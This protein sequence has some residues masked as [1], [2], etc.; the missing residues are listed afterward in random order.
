MEIPSSVLESAGI[1]QNCFIKFNEYDEHKTFA[2]TIQSELVGLYHRTDEALQIK[3]E[4]E[5][6]LDSF[7]ERI[8]VVDVPDIEWQK[9][10]KRWMPKHEEVHV[11]DDSNDTHKRTMPFKVSRKSNYSKVDRDAGSFA[12]SLGCK[13][14]QK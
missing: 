8:E 3:V 5:E 4:P 1:C 6:F 13:F 2:E 9:T 11:V 12:P 10:P 14:R 7:E